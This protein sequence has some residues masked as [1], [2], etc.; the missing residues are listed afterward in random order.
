MP[1]SKSPIVEFKGKPAL[2]ICSSETGLSALIENSKKISK[3]AD[4]LLL[5]DYSERAMARALP[6]YV[7]ATIRFSDGSARSK[8]MQVEMLMLVCGTMNIG[9]A[10]RDC[11]AKDNDKFLVFASSEGLFS[12]FAKANGI[13]RIRGVTLRLDPEI[14]GNVAITELLND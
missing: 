11:G 3:G 2:Y 8:S 13:K 6:A 5:F 10:L 12:K 14:T 9:K 1:A 4:L 7:N